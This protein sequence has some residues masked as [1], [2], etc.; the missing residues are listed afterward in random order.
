[1][2]DELSLHAGP[3]AHDGSPSWTLHDPMRS[4]FFRLSWPAF[5]VLSRWHL[6]SPEAIAQAVAL[7]TTLKLE[8]SD[9]LDVA[10]F[11]SQNQLLKP[12]SCKDTDRL[13]EMRDARKSSWPVWLLH[14]YLFF[15]IPLLRPDHL[16]AK[17]HPY[18]AWLGSRP[19][20]FATVL[21]LL[22][23][24]WQIG[25]RW[26]L[27]KTTFVD[28]VSISGLATFAVA[29]GLAK[30]IHEL[31][32][33]FAAKA[34]G[35]R[36][37]TMGVAFLVMWPVLYTDVND[38]WKLTER[39]QRLLIGGAGILSELT[40]AAWASLAWG[41]LPEGPLRSMAFTLA[42]TTWISSLV[43]NLSPFMRFD[44][45]FLVMDA[46]D[47][48]NLHPRAFALARWRL[49]KFLFGLD[50]Q[51]PERLPR[52]TQTGLIVFAWAVWL[53]RLILF[54]GIA[55]LVYH[56]FIK[57]VG[58]LLFA[59]EVGWFI[60]RPIAREMLEWQ[61]RWAE[62]RASRRSRTT[63][64]VL[65][66]AL[67]ILFL[68]WNGRIVAPALLKASEHVRVFAP[69][70][71]LLDA[72]LV[73]EGQ[74]VAAGDV[75]ARLVNPDIALRLEQA[76]KQANI[77]KYELSII[78]FDDGLR[79][80]S[81]AI[82]Q[83]FEAA[84]AQQA[85]L[86]NDLDRLTLTAPFAGIATD[87]SPSLQPGQWIGSKDA[88]MA[89][90]QGAVI[91][92]YVAEEDLPRIKKGDDAAFFT[93]GALSRYDA[94]VTAIDRMAVRNLAE[95]SLAVSFGGVIPA[96]FD[97]QFLVPDQSLYRVRL[98]LVGQTQDLAV[99]VLG[100]AQINGERRSFL[101]RFL[102]YILSVVIRESGM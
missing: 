43:I 15:R 8:A 17:A 42:A 89:I 21:A 76:T 22:V 49:R 53:Y 31:G 74:R 19:F 48:P 32:H 95:P 81:Q 30:I 60:V 7:E 4:Q 12:Q 100:E 90:R 94:A 34:Q 80:R 33:A 57:A 91:E 51:A 47:I 18:V 6:Q 38:A 68:P 10:S 2:R 27:F 79:A 36:V 58:V 64:A 59:V 37:P 99:P 75:L 25:Q 87:L 85:A 20:R 61:K 93:D 23:G 26:E 62:I 86:Q 40:L 1:M 3:A 77:F 101:G 44:G 52:A 73:K 98:A 88:L 24:L 67:L 16:L 56:F 13:L 92:A 83:E 41:L 69:S 63:W 102:R 78:A 50:D 82:A 84:L 5:E 11:L 35:C 29:L 72:V 39:R 70:P 97:H 45:Y 71:G 46:L 9:V 96:R 55:A 28:H 14:H 66:A 65:A 54:L